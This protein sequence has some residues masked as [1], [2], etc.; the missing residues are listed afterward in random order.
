MKNKKFTKKD[1]LKLSGITLLI[2]VVAILGISLLA[3]A[4]AENPDIKTADIQTVGSNILA[5]GSTDS[6]NKATLTFQIGGKLV[7]L[8]F[9]EGDTVYAGQTVAQL[10]SSDLQRK[11]QMAL[12]TYQSTRDTFDQTQQNSQD[13][14]AQNQQKTSL[15]Q[16]GAGVSGDTQVNV[17]NDIVKRLLDQNQ[18]NLDNSVLNVE[19]ANSAVQLSTLTSP[20]NGIVMHEDATNAGTN[21]SPAATFVIADPSS[22]VFSANVRQ[23][24]IDFISVGNEATITLDSNPSNKI[25]GTVDK[26][27][28]QKTVL[29]TGESVYK[30]D[31]KANG[32]NSSQAILGQTGTVLIKSNFTQKVMLVPSWT[33]LG[34]NYVW[35]M[36]NNKPVLKK[37]EVGDTT[38]ER[39]E[40][41]GG[42]SDN[43][44]VIT[45][46]ASVISKNY[47]LL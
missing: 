47:T 3:K 8:P 7:Y 24:D 27:Y 33:V 44:K 41:M 2:V 45:N 28:P 29:P 43:D 12:N 20:I 39:T 1:F 30:V 26:I 4:S 25:T 36:E 18:M 31:I 13:N 37:V 22:M 11:L 10:D 32:L 17:I 38:N 9:K 46:P 40:I 34:N 6:Q 15:N 23:Q 35:V 21:I 42:L 19:L 14:I 5:N 16:Q